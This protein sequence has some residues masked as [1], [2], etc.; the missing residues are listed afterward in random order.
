MASMK[1]SLAQGRLP[2]ATPTPARPPLSQDTAV[3]LRHVDDARTEVQHLRQ[4]VEAKQSASAEEGDEEL[5][6]LR[7]R[8]KAAQERLDE[9]QQMYER[10]QR[11]TTGPEAARQSERR[12]SPRFKLDGTKLTVRRC[13][14]FGTLAKKNI[15]SALVDLSEGGV[16]AVVS[17]EVRPGDT[18]HVRIE[19]PSFQETIEARGKVVRVIEID[20]HNAYQVGVQFAALDHKAQS[21]IRY[22]QRYVASQAGGN[23]KQP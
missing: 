15:A 14:W 6:R 22:M 17:E 20:A 13:L 18:L 12:L 23:A 10:K 1:E 7:R 8:L 11:T 9:Y 5:S 21:R 3:I 4:Q 16:G 2:R 19:V